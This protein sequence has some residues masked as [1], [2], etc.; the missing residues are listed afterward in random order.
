MGHLLA[1]INGVEPE[2]IKQILINDAT[3]HAREGLFLE[4][5]WINEDNGDEVLFL[6]KAF[7]LKQARKFIDKVHGQTLKVDPDAPL[8]VMTYLEEM[9]NN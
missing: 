3:A 6:F 8:P 4:H 5:L 7:D 9:L 2:L 1:R